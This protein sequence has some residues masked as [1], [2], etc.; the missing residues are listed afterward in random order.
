MLLV[1]LGRCSVLGQLL[2]SPLCPYLKPTTFKQ[3]CELVF[4]TFDTNGDG[5]LSCD[6]FIDWI[7]QVDSSRPAKA[8]KGWAVDQ[9]C[10][11]LPLEARLREVVEAS[12]YV[13]IPHHTLHKHWKAIPHLMIDW[14]MERLIGYHQESFKLHGAWPF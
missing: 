8:A 14:V 7:W 6:E 9:S 11:A 2:A 13:K 10:E 5:K 4:K 12:P 3:D 1:V